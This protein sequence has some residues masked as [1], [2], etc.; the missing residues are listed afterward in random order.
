MNLFFVYVDKNK[1]CKEEIDSSN[2]SRIKFLEKQYLAKV[3]YNQEMV[4]R[5]IVKLEKVIFK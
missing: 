2:K 3:F 5:Y 4:N 1:I